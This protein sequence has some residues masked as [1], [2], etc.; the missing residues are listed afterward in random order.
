MLTGINIVIIGGDA[1]QIEVIN[2]LIK[3]DATLTLLGMENLQEKYPNLN[4]AEFNVNNLKTADAILLPIV[5][6][7][8][9]GN[10]ESIFTSHP[11]KLTDELF[12]SLPK[13]C[14]IYTGI[15]GNFLKNTC[16]KYQINLIEMLNLDEVAILNSIPTAE[17]ALLYAIQNTEFTIHD[18]N[19]L[20]VGFGRVG[21]TLARVLYGL[22]AHVF[23]I[24][25]EQRK[26]AR[27]Y[28]LGYTPIK[29]NNLINRDYDIDIIF[30]TVPAPIL[31]AKV[32]ANLSQ[33]TLIIDLASKPG[34]TDFRY[35]EKRGIK[36]ILAPSLPG[37]VAPKTAGK[38]L[39]NTISRL[40]LEQYNNQEEY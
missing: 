19:S 8:D 39:G 21:M 16:A 4:F 5:G 38:I 1:R 24:E 27:A 17:G 20:I 7:D 3:M 40:I 23:I 6:T 30:N 35:A 2:H 32:I 26:I 25:K 11:I 9:E 28:E 18:S 37:I 10:I 14:T 29:F 36:A 15:A 34:G 33:N 22:G 31:T 13:K 12:E